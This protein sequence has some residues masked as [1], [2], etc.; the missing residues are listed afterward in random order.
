M[1]YSA[2]PPAPSTGNAVRPMCGKRLTPPIL[3]DVRQYLPAS[4]LRN[5]FI[6]APKSMINAENRL[7]APPVTT[8]PRTGIAFLHEDFPCGGA[9]RVTID[10]A[11]FLANHNCRVY[12]LTANFQEDRKSVV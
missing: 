4:F 12:V 6:S 9:E 5:I 11:N 2:P 8:I 7:I 10:I 1:T 3:G